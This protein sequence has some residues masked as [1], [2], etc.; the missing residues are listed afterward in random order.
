MTD[1]TQHPRDEAAEG[2]DEFLAIASQGPV[3]EL[4]PH[5]LLVT[6][7]IPWSRIGSVEE[8]ATEGE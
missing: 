7:F 6:I 2:L 4:T 3:A 8:N 5:G 1:Q